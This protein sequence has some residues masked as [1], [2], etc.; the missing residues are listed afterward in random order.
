M[1]DLRR[2]NEFDILRAAILLLVASGAATAGAPKGWLLAGSR[3]AVYETDVDSTAVYNGA[4]S[5]FLR[6]DGPVPEGFGTLMQSLAA[7]DYVGRRVRLSGFVK[8]EGVTRWAGLWM[9]VDKGS[10]PVAFDNMQTRPIKGSTGWRSYEV[11]LDVPQDATGVA[12]GILMDGPGTVWLNSVK[13][14]VVGTD[15]ALTGFDQTP[16]EKPVNLGFEQK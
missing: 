16:P 4:P 12:F 2:K 11:V 7:T 1:S 8:S 10:K 13:L 3:P 14:D 15:V 6:S 5:A 9:R